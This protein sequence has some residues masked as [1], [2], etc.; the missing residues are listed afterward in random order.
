ME[1]PSF[2]KTPAPEVDVGNKVKLVLLHNTK[3]DVHKYF[4]QLFVNTFV[5]I[6][7]LNTIFYTRI[8]FVL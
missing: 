2:E 7:M 3:A 4:P 5:S 6:A 8:S 1:V